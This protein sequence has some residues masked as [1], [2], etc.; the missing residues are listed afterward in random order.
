MISAKA[1]VCGI[2]AYPVEHS[3]S[4][5]MHNFYGE[6]LGL[7]FAYV[8]LKVEPHRVREAVE[9]AFALN[10]AGMNVTVPHKQSVIPFLKELDPAAA[11]IGA[12]NTLVRTEE[13][14][15]GYNTDAPGLARAMAE[16]GFCA[17]GRDCLLIGAG[18][19]AKAAAYVLGKGGASSVTILNRSV[20]KAQRL[21][22]EMNRLLGGERMK[23]MALADWQN[24]SGNG[25]LA[26][27]TT[28]VGMYPHTDQAPIEESAFYEKISEAL[29]VIYTP[30]ETRFMKLA[31]EA[32]ARVSNGLN[33]LIYQG[34]EAFELW[35]AG[36]KVPD[37]VIRAA[38]RR[39][40]RIL[41]SGNRHLVLIG[42]MGA[43]KTTV[44]QVLAEMT[45]RSLLDTDQLI[46]AEAGMTISRIFETQGEDAFRRMETAVLEKLLAQTDA[47]VI[48]V[49]GGL[50]L[51]AENRA[52]LEQLGETFYLRVKPET[53]LVR[54]AGDTTRPLLAGPD[55]EG[56]VEE[57]LSFRGPIYEEAADFVIDAD[58]RSP[59]EAAAAVMERSILL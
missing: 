27:Q 32:G 19:A 15:K 41:G 56:R 9:G 42:F 35:N 43:G 26:V 18:G 28:S 51:R 39:M 12:V 16:A 14:F 59:R 13:G 1:K 8:P 57:L 23:A 53:V 22:E 50:P 24:L 33:M 29:D 46:E 4:P 45:N 17:D 38:R 11:A 20:E 10:L 21:A 3:L 55:A 34:I 37:S 2:M 54:L 52:F 47:A 49:G 48:S 31:K 7:D 40:Q 25:Y 44:G 5:D 58:A 6:Q 36:V 30:A